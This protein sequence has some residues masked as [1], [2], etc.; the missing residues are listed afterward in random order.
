M[1][2]GIIVAPDGTPWVALLGTNK[3]ASIGP[4]TLTLREYGLPHEDAAPR[5]LVATSNGQI[6]YVDFRRGYLGHLDPDTGVIREWEAP[7]QAHSG[8]YGMVVDD[9]D[10]IWFVETGDRPNQLVGFSTMTEAFISITPIPS[11]AGSVRHMF[12]DPRSRAI[13]FGTDNNTI[14][15]AMVPEN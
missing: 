14:G 10:R 11:G 1:P 9:L 6:Y 4:A 2:D 3:L 5:R 13:W 15:R 8:P 12:F 7:S